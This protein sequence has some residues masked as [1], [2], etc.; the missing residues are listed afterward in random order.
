MLWARD[1][2]ESQ[3]DI[4]HAELVAL[5][6]TETGGLLRTAGGPAPSSNKERILHIDVHQLLEEEDTTNM[7]ITPRCLY[8]VILLFTLNSRAIRKASV[9]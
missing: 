6:A 9:V 8:G 4:A 2:G 3:A 7:E 5:K 1:G